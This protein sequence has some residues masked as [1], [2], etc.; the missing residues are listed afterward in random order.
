MEAR[1]FFIFAVYG[2]ARFEILVG[3]L[4]PFDCVVQQTLDFE[5]WSC[6]KRQGATQMYKK[7]RGPWLNGIRAPSRL[8]N[9]R[10]SPKEGERRRKEEKEWNE[11]LLFLQLCHC[12]KKNPA[13]DVV[14]DIAS[15]GGNVIFCHTC[16]NLKKKKID[17]WFCR[18]QAKL[19]KIP[20]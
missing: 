20:L 15:Q 2:I 11:R 5:V 1:A 7:R 6:F 19:E 12:G 4:A 17:I 16:V 9:P 8:P 3:L 13:L 18:S 14:G 10:Q